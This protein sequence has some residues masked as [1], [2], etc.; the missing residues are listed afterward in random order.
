[1]NFFFFY[2]LG[3]ECN[4][5][6]AFPSN[7]NRTALHAACSKGHLM[8]VY[9]LLQAGADPNLVDDKMKSPIRMAAK[10]GHT[11]VVQFLMTYEGAPEIKV[12]FRFN[13][14]YNNVY[15]F[16]YYIVIIEGYSGYD[17]TSFGC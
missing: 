7:H 6:Y 16:S 12:L 4:L 3:A 2:I 15:H 17:F 10:N 1:M 13:L 11:D 8:L 5:S 14:C 9:L